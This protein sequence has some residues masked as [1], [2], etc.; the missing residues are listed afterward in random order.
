M[1]IL[2]YLR[3]FKNVLQI[4]IKIAVIKKHVEFWWI[5][6]ITTK[7]ECNNSENV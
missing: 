1:Q 6:S 2:S 7:K 5:T 3:K 4:S